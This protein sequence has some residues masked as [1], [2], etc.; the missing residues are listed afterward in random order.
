MRRRRRA[1]ACFGSPLP[2][3]TTILDVDTLIVE[4]ILTSTERVAAY[5]GVQL[6]EAI[7]HQLIDALLSGELPM[8]LQHD[9]RRPLKATVIEAAVR[10][11]PNGHKEVWF[12]F[13]VDAD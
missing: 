13:E 7:L 12:S 6:D 4:G 5:G 1:L 2:N 11:R 8:V 3:G 10:S 9:V